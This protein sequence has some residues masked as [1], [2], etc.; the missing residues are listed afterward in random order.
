M[1]KKKSD[2]EKAKNKAPD[3]AKMFNKKMSRVFVE[4]IGDVTVPDQSQ[5]MELPRQTTSVGFDPHDTSIIQHEEQQPK[6]T[7]QKRG[8]C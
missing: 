3:S 5:S 6:Q 2:I 8:L 7:L 4:E 1:E